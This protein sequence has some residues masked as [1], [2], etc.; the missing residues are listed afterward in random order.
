VALAL[1]R[2]AS[3]HHGLDEEGVLAYSVLALLLIFALEFLRRRYAPR[4][5][6]ID[7]VPPTY[8]LYLPL[9]PRVPPTERS[10]SDELAAAMREA[11][12][13]PHPVE[14]AAPWECPNCGVENPAEFEICWK[15][16]S[17]PSRKVS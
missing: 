15:C 2:E 3:R 16:Q 11:K 8:E 12:A 4:L 7:V 9:E 1:I 6:R 17:S 14:E 13:A 10:A 5:A